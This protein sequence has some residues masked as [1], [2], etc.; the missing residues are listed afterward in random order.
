MQ[1]AQR[2]TYIVYVYHLHRQSFT[3]PEKRA[4]AGNVNP[5]EPETQMA[6]TRGRV[7]TLFR[8]LPP[9]NSVMSPTTVCATLPQISGLEKPRNSPRNWVDSTEL[10]RVR[11]LARELIMVTSWIRVKLILHPVE[12]SREKTESMM[13]RSWI[14]SFD[15]H[16]LDSFKD[17]RPWR[18]CQRTSELWQ[19]STKSEKHY[20]ESTKNEGMTNARSTHVGGP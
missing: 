17:Q 15:E 7:S 12:E 9:A 18:T 11:Q 6:S 8:S 20:G 5:V 14:N 10:G 19:C 2:S 1:G 16:T 13:L 4:R 3:S